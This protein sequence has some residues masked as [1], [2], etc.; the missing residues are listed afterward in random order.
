LLLRTFA[1]LSS[2]TSAICKFRLS[3]GIFML[4]GSMNTAIEIID[5]DFSRTHNFH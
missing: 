5:I 1:F 3:P 2:I 4:L